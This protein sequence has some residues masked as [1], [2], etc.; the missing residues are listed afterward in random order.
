MRKSKSGNLQLVPLAPEA[1]SSRNLFHTFRDPELLSDWPLQERAFSSAH[2]FRLPRSATTPASILERW[3]PE[4][5]SLPRISRGC[6]L[7]TEYLAW[8]AHL[9]D[10]APFASS[11]VTAYTA[12]RPQTSEDCHSR[13]CCG[14]QRLRIA[15]PQSVRGRTAVFRNGKLSPASSQHWLW[16]NLAGT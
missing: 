16:P 5:S 3:K 15:L 2:L 9:D 11:V 10:W 12:R 14:T 8:A 4:D 1:S 6:R 7:R 13:R